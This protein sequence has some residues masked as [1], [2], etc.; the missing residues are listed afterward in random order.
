VN[1]WEHAALA[2]VSL[3]CIISMSQMLKRSRR[4]LADARC[5]LGHHR[6]FNER[7]LAERRQMRAELDACRADIRQVT[8]ERDALR[9]QIS[10]EGQPRVGGKFAG[11]GR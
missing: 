3:V 11:V 5:A 9:R 10:R 7:F 4:A 1:G 6:R 8:A 2:V